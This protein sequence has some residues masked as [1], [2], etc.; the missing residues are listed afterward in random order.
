MRKRLIHLT[1]LWALCGQS[2]WVVTPN[3]AQA[4]PEVMIADLEKNHGRA[5]LLLASL[6]LINRDSVGARLMSDLL[7][8]AGE[9]AQSDL[10]LLLSKGLIIQKEPCAYAA[11]DDV[12]PH[13]MAT[14]S[15]KA[16]AT[17]ANRV[18]KVLLQQFPPVIGCARDAMRR[19]L[20]LMKHV[21]LLLRMHI[22]SLSPETSLALGLRYCLILEFIQEEEAKED[23]DQLLSHMHAQLQR[24][25]IRDPYLKAVFHQL[26][27]RRLAERGLAPLALASWAK[28]EE[29]FREVG[30]S[31]GYVEYGALLIFDI[32]GFLY[33]KGD[34]EGARAALERASALGDWQDEPDLNEG[35]KLLGRM[36]ARLAQ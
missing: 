21:G 17:V 5:A 27:G 15:P 23:R 19:D 10:Q 6:C 1:I 16:L 35:K 4:A 3:E 22:G 11:L 26:H 13:V 31:K 12:Y 18:A 14:L 29:A 32:G 8:A 30:D 9:G 25:E 33:D 20:S 2:A 7:E 24:G 28:S 36:L 34:F